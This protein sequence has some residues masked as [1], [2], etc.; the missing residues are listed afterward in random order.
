VSQ[1]QTLEQNDV[2]L[3]AFNEVICNAAADD[4]AADDDDPASR[5]D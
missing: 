1:L 5:G 4:A 2:A 3:P